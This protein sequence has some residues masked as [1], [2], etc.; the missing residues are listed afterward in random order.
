[1]IADGYFLPKLSS[2]EPWINFFVQAC[3][4]LFELTV[5][6]KGSNYHQE[7]LCMPLFDTRRA[8]SQQML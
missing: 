1:M 5:A 7:P 6:H 4:S 2:C 3:L 8:I